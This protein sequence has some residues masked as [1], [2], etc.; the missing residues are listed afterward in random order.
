MIETLSRIRKFIQLGLLAVV[1]SL[2]GFA[3]AEDPLT[4]QPGEQLVSLAVE[5]MT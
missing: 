3:Y 1:L 5:N 2:A 4:L